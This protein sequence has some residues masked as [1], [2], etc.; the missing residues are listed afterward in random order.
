MRTG[1]YAGSFDPMT[2]GHLDV[3]VQAL[4]FCDRIVI[5]VGVSPTKKPMFSFEERE[6]MIVKS[7]AET[8]PER[9]GDVSVASFSDLTVTTARKA[10]A[11]LIVRGLRDSGDFNYEM[12][13]AGMNA[14]MAPDLQTVFLPAR[15][16]NRHITATLV[17]QIAGMGGDVS[18]FV[19]EPV[20]QAI[21]A[22]RKGE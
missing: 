1:F 11:S 8:L 20:D 10:G 22:Q 13:I 17:R 3:L 7:L 14:E 21:R 18:S 19:P 4:S 12:Q 2:N 9:A 16:A 15:A 6:A 5:G